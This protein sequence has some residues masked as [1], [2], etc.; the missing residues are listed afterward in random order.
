MREL[1][2]IGRLELAEVLRSRWIALCLG[3]YAVLGGVFVLGA[4][5]ESGVLGFTGMGR[6]LFALCHA[7]VLVLPLL[8]L[9]ATGQVVN[10]A[11][12][13]GALELLF[14]H[15]VSRGGW[16]TAVSLVRLAALLLPLMLLLPALA[17]Y[18]RLAFGEAVPWA[19]LLRALAV[20]TSLLLASV[21]T[22]LFLSCHVRNQAK[23]L[24]LL[25]LVWAAGVA[26]LDFA[27]AGLMLQWRLD[28]RAV[29]ALSALNPVQCARMALLSAAEP[30]LS[31]L[32]PVGFF[33]AHRIGATG[34]LVLGLLWPTLLGCCAWL[35]TL[36]SLSRGDLV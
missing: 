8:G 6:V 11:R 25:L 17:I 24:M 33:L 13:E 19:F 28:P 18:G 10:R 20:S 15:P 22:G 14:S 2:A 34:L 27:L 7:L 21:G 9:T 12:E 23:A 32:G 26:L 29:F 30:E 36:R 5:R 1:A 3:L 16:F 31:T 4:M 35:L